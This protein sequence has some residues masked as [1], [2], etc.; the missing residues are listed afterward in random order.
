M[1]K[2]DK[3]PSLLQAIEDAYKEKTKHDELTVT[4]GDLVLIREYCNQLQEQCLHLSTK[5]EIEASRRRDTNDLLETF[6]RESRKVYLCSYL[7]N[8]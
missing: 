4:M 6:R 8:N 5:V 3:I 2:F 7:R 1:A